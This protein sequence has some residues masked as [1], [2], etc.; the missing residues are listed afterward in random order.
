M[1]LVTGRIFSTSSFQLLLISAIINI[2]S[3]VILA[4]LLNVL[5]QLL[6]WKKN[7][8]PVVFHWFPFI[9][10]AITYGQEPTKFLKDCQAKVCHMIIP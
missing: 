3:L 7:E 4:V 6:F 5:K 8:P 10:S 1:A 2:T 9:G